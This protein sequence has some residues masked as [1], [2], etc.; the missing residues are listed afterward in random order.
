M[1]E[2]IFDQ[3]K[4]SVHFQIQISQPHV[5]QEVYVFLSS[6]EKKLRFLMK[7]IQDLYPCS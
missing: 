6:A 1:L 3:L 2:W 5:I 7:T 4:G